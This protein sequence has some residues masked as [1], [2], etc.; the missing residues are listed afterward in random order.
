MASLERIIADLALNG[1][2]DRVWNA[3][4]HYSRA[5]IMPKFERVFIQPAIDFWAEVEA[6][7]IQ[8]VWSV[9]PSELPV[10]KDRCCCRQN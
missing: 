8:D 7:G 2:P 5:E 10:L 3:Y 4:K 1:I 6:R 9:E